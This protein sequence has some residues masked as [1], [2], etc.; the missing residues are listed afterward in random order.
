MRFEKKGKFISR[1]IRS[2]DIWSRV[3]EVAYKLSFPTCCS[4]VHPVFH[5]SM[6]RKYVS[7]K[8][9]VLSID[10]FVLGPDLSFE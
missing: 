4:N 5:V 7:D 3:G 9:C 1:F 8:F 2:F 6:L 10:S